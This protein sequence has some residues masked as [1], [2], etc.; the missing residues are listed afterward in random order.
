MLAEIAEV[1]G[2]AIAN[3]RNLMAERRASDLHSLLET[4][5]ELGASLDPQKVTFTLVH[6]AAAV[7]GYQTAAVG[8]VKGAR[9]ELAAVSGQTSVDPTLPKNRALIDVLTWAAELNEGFY[10]VQGDDG[11]IDTERV[12]TREK[13]RAYFQ[14]T[15]VRSFLAIP[16][17]DDEGRL[18]V[19][20]LEA[21][22]PYAFSERDIEAATLLGVQATVAIR[23]AVLY[24]QIPMLRV[25]QPLG[26]RREQIAR[27][28][29]ARKA[30]CAGAGLLAVALMLVPV[31]L[32]IG[33][34]ARVLPVVRLSATAE[35]EGRVARVLVREGS[36]VEAGQVVAELDDADLRGGLE[37]ARARYEAAMREQSLK[38]AE[39]EVAGAAVEAARLEGLRAEVALWET[40]V[41]R[42]AIRSATS[43]IVATPRVEEKTGSRLERGEVFCEI[44]DPASQ[45]V[46][47]A[48]PERDAGLVQAGMQVK[49][50][51][52]A[53][54]TS[55]L[56]GMIDRMG[57]TATPVENGRVVL[58]RARIGP[59][60]PP[61]AT[62]MTGQAKISVGNT[63]LGRVILRRPARWF[64][65][66]LWGLLP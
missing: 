55:S 12:E 20:A 36:R 54:P 39:G 35:V 44:V 27:S 58:A 60:S 40:R 33:A 47:V 11:A 48:I 8:L 32:R 15:G 52:H 1:A 57:V 38:R 18:G 61:L 45:A 22:E 9:L 46:E 6:K 43:G 62:G 3:A 51:L 66:W 65:S 14:A 21:A 17:S 26:Q 41:A 13:F 50:K 37:D 63:A 4:T 59:A 31:P 19:F 64:W 56:R 53:F 16:L 24:K 10:V 2:V 5:Q 29:W 42:T 25:M 28:P 30:S 23:N 7:I 49:I 34:D